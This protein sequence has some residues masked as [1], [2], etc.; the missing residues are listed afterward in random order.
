MIILKMNK[1]NI[2]KIIEL[3]I[4]LLAQD[5]IWKKHTQ[6]DIRNYIGEFK[7]RMGGQ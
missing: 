3:G 5:L 4:N 7:F 6:K 2:T 1:I